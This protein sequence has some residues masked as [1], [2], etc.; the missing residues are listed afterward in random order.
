[1]KIMTSGDSKM[2]Q[3]NVDSRVASFW[4][5]ESGDWGQK[6]GKPTSYFYRRQTFYKFFESTGL[7]NASILDY[8]CGSGDIT[9]PMLQ[10]GHVITG[11][12][13]AEK[14]VERASERAKHFGLEKN[15]SYH[16]ISESVMS[17]IAAQK[18]DV[19]VCSSVL[20]Y[21]DDDAVLLRMFH[22]CLN[23]GGY[24]LVSVPDS[25]SIFCKMDRWMYAN[26]KIL[27]G[28]VPSEKL[29]YLDIQKRQYKISEFV[30]DLK[31]IGFDFLKK[32]HNSITL[33]RGALME[34]ASNVPGIGMLALMM[35]RKSV[36]S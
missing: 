9:F 33:Q 25:R 29:G 35:F 7:K 28:F 20:E 15:A 24:L 4:D 27:P 2:T 31:A 26:K 18:F 11:V 30:R 19:V 6:Y 32:K 12:D 17:K 23:E 8:G 14:M 5:S 10:D 34:M 22:S 1:M 13:I 3:T 36:K 21:V 16:H